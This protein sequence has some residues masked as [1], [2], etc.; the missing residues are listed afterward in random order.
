MAA[1]LG[2]TVSELTGG[3]FANGAATAALSAAV[4]EGVAKLPSRDES[5]A[6][7]NPLHAMSEEE[8]LEVWDAIMK[9]VGVNQGKRIAD[10]HQGVARYLTENLYEIG[11]VLGFE[12]GAGIVKIGDGWGFEQ[13]HTEFDPNGV[14]PSDSTINWHN[15]PSGDNSIGGTFSGYKSKSRVNTE[16]TLQMAWGNFYKQ[17]I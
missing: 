15:H 9:K 14:S 4:S 12:M 3:K 2:G 13:L 17:N 1:I 6:R 11:D 10:T 5:G 7:I 8:Q 16:E